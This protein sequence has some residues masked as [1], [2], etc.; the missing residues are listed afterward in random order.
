MISIG[1]PIWSQPPTI[2]TQWKF[3]VNISTNKNTFSLGCPF[4]IVDLFICIFKCVQNRVV[5]YIY[6]C[7]YI[8][9]I[10]TYVCIDIYY[11]IIHTCM[12]TYII[13]T[14]VPIWS[15]MYLTYPL[16]WLSY[17]KDDDQPRPLFNGN[18]RILR[19]CNHHFWLETPCW[20]QKAKFLLVK[21]N[22]VTNHVH[23]FH[24]F[25]PQN[26]VKSQLLAGYI[27]Y[28]YIYIHIHIYI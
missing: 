9:I 17:G 24:I 7:I 1:D 4:K 25:S 23:D 28:I 19:W 3:E 26:Q 27:S 14:Y 18:I 11:I 13:Y 15:N 5:I 2:C 8:Y 12:Y 6:I 22:N 16:K 10:Y 20:P 21:C